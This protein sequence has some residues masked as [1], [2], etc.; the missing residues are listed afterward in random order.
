MRRHAFE[1]TPQYLTYL[2]TENH[3]C[4]RYEELSRHHIEQHMK[5]TAFR[6]LTGA[7]IAVLF[8]PSS[9]QTRVRAQA[10]AA[11]AGLATIDGK[12]IS[13]VVV[14][15]RNVD[16]GQLLGTSAATAAGEFSFTGLVPGNYIVEMVSANG[17]IIGT[18]DVIR[19]TPAVMVADNIT[20]GASSAAVA[21]AGGMGAGPATGAG[22][23]GTSGLSS[24]ILAVLAV[25][26]TLGT[27]AIVAVANDASPSR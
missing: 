14:R 1:K 11:I 4:R 22:V 27:T 7:L 3:I 18:S 21:A 9:E 19:L 12:P 26:A 17:T 6:V 16:S 5:K 25:G 15:L 24:T 13:N 10:G 8:L 20:V 2:A 23:G